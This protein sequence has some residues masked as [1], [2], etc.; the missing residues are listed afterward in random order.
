ML[1][2]SHVNINNFI[3]LDDKT[4]EKEEIIKEELEDEKKAEF[5]VPSSAVR[6]M[7][8]KKTIPKTSEDSTN[9]ETLEDSNNVIT[10]T[11]I[12]TR[13]ARST[14]VGR[15]KEEHDGQSDT[16]PTSVEN[17]RLVRLRGSP[18]Q[19]P[20]GDLQDLPERGRPRRGSGATS[21]S[22]SPATET[23]EATRD[24]ESD[25]SYAPKSSSRLRQGKK[26]NYIILLSE[27]LYVFTKFFRKI[28]SYQQQSGQ[29]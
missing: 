16:P 19:T 29:Q 5:S 20:G 24:S 18:A 27:V 2:L 12:S 28:S 26:V 8:N 14:R 11:P 3:V 1:L 6:E 7:R 25:S 15:L 22:S 4:M 10:S 21:R 9:D 17:R 13:T 23:D